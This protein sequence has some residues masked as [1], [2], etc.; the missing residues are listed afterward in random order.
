MLPL[1]RKSHSYGEYVFDHAWANAYHRH[2]INYYPKLV[3][4]IPFTPV[5]GPRLLCAANQDEKALLPAFADFVIGLVNDNAF[6][7]FHLL[8]ASKEQSDVLFGSN[9]L[10][11]QAVQFEWKNYHYCSFD[12]YLDKMVSRKRKSIRKERAN[13]AKQG[14]TIEKKSG[15]SITPED[16]AHFCRCYQQ[17]YLKRS[18]HSGYLTPECFVSLFS[19]MADQILLINAFRNEESIASALFFF[20]KKA[21]YGR[22]WGS[23]EEIN[24]LHFECCYYQG[25]EFAIDNNLET[26]N[27]GTQGEHKILRGFEPVYSYSN[28]YLA[29]PAFHDAVKHFLSE[30]KAH[31]AEYKK[32]AE[33]LLPF[34]E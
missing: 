31:V 17:T 11:R 16:I 21:L 14:V 13:V 32:D 22:Y 29:E 24:G 19:D 4:A 26:F 23:L 34:K 15:A 2:G 6:S 7:S 27:P 9:M 1:Y 8:F 33:S 28:H 3:S 12:D 30:E 25:I 10:Q 18:G 5:T 20:D